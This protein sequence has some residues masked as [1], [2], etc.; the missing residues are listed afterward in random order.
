MQTS[1]QAQETDSAAAEAQGSVPPL[2]IPTRGAG[3]LSDQPEATRLGQLL[4]GR[5]LQR[6]LQLHSELGGEEGPAPFDAC[7][8]TQGLR[9][10]AVEYAVVVRDLETVQQLPDSSATAESRPSR[11]GPINLEVKQTGER[12]AGKPHAAIDVA[13][14]GNVA[15]S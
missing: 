7:P 13:G 2:P 6:V 14:T 10:D 15:W 4:R 3:D 12:S 8:E 9:L 5:P 1:H 11:I